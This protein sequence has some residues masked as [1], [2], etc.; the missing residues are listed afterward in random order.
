[1]HN[2]TELFR[3]ARF[4]VSGGIAASVSLIVLHVFTEYLGVLYLISSMYAFVLSFGFSFLLQKFWTFQN[5]ELSLASRQLLCHLLLATVNLLLNTL[6]MYVLVEYMHMW[7]MLAQVIA[8][9]FIAIETF[10]LLRVIY[11]SQTVS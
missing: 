8:S 11:R 7:Y 10:I 9:A 6:L 2:K 1:M 3:I 4:L 5:G